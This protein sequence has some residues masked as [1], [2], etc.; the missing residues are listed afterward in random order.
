MKKETTI[1]DIAKTLNISA[2]TVSRGLQKHDTISLK[3]QKRIADTA[4][5]LG[6]RSNN[7][8]SN[9]RKQKT[10][11]IGVMLHELHSSFISSV[12]AGI[13]KIT[14]EANYDLII[15][16]SSESYKKEAANAHNFFHKRVDGLIAALAFDT[17]DMSHFDPFFDRNIP[18]VFFDRVEETSKGTKV[19]I[20]N[21]KA[22][23]DA[24]QH[25]IDQGCKRIAHITSN[26]KRNVYELRFEGFLNALKHN[27]IPFDDS[28]LFITELTK[29]MCMETM[30]KVINLSPLPDGIFATNDLIGA[31][32]IQVL[33]EN[34]LSVPK[35]I[36]IVGFN[37]D[38]LSII[39]DPK[40]S[41]I[42]YPGFELGEIAAK[43]LIAQLEGKEDASENQTIII[44][45]DLICRE[46]SMRKK[47]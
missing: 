9:L 13:E 43:K 2:T 25:L 30:R 42:N 15:G 17:E 28:M 8:A 29:D 3:T 41:T 19:I 23:Y 21:E 14:A 39:T 31:I 7:F 36:A 12:L 34:S 38:I 32:A 1:Y 22:G 20:D 35:D 24:T 6:Y 47:S 4:K 5:E 44:K 33:K 26:L 10:N 16:H 18:V 27:N 37:N 46:S 45:S 11:T 40:L